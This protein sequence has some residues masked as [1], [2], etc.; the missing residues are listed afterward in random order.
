MKATKVA[1]NNEEKNGRTLDASTG[2]LREQVSEREYLVLFFKLL[3]LRRN[4]K[5][6]EKR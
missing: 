5:K 3:T 4:R 1:I 6:Y 2:G